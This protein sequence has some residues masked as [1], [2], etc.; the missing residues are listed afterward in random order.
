MN[1]LHLKILLCVSMLADHIG[2]L[3][4]ELGSP[5]YTAFRSFGRMALPLVC[6]L[7]VEGYYHTRKKGQYALRL[8]IFAVLSEIPYANLVARQ[9]LEVAEFIKSEGV[10]NFAEL[11]A[12]Q[13]TL[14]ADRILQIVNVL[15]TLLMCLLMVWVMDI[16]SRRAEAKALARASQEQKQA[17]SIHSVGKIAML[18]LTV[19][20]VLLITYI[21]R[22]DYWMLAPM[23]ALAFFCFRKEKETQLVVAV[24]IAVVYAGSIPYAIGSLLAV[25]AIKLYNGK[26]GYVQG[27]NPLLQYSFYLFYPLHLAVL[28]LLRYA[29]FA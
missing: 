12:K 21:F 6:Y 16:I 4:L 17:T 5:L 10:S 8:G 2:L 27:K 1:R 7:L 28:L 14:Y 13:Q 25:G 20:A 24:M 22:M 15:F 23:Y 26:L 11:T 29:V 3:F 9:R 19:L 18:A